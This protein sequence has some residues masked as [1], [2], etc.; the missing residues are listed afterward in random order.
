VNRDIDFG[1][2]EAL[3]GFL[4]HDPDVMMVGEVRDEETAKLA[5]DAAQ[6]GHLVFATLHTNSALDAFNRLT[7]LGVD[8]ADAASSVIGVQAQ[9]L[10]RC[11][12]PQC[13]EIVKATDDQRRY[14]ERYRKRIEANLDPEANC[15]DAKELVGVLD[16]W[17][18]AGDTYRS[19]GCGSCN[20]T[21]YH[22]Q[23]AA[24]EIYLVGN[25]SE[26]L[27]ML[28]EKK[29]ISSLQKHFDRQGFLTVA[30]QMMR[31]FARHETTYAEIE[32][33]IPLL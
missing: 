17:L 2:K 31:M 5:I 20:H 27:D 16:Q 19:S 6:S 25:D 3:P 9:R 30:S 12:C 14:V 21:G 8:R 26:A 28:Y 13:R 10:I 24:M 4:R 11:L 1:F 23:T 7:R 18:L 22:R 32:P 33:Y 29:P 15:R